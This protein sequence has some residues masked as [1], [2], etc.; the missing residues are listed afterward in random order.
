MQLDQQRSHRNHTMRMPKWS[1]KLKF[2]LPEY[3]SPRNTWRRK[4]YAAAVA[5]ANKQGGSYP[6]DAKLAVEVKLYLR[7]RAL[8]IHDVDN[9]LKDVLD[10]L[11]GRM[12]GSKA[13]RQFVPIIH[14]DRQVYRVVI[15]KSSP[16]GQSHELGHVLVLQLK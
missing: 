2:R 16:P 15:S 7:G 6:E 11:Q 3:I 5:A 13:V 10:A 4:I 14:N 9:R 12:G 1:Q 8:E